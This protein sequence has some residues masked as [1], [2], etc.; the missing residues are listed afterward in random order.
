MSSRSR[1]CAQGARGHVRP[2]TERPSPVSAN[3]A[4]Q[5]VCSPMTLSTAVV[6][7]PLGVSGGGGA[8][9][10]S[11]QAPL[12]DTRWGRVGGGATGQQAAARRASRFYLEGA[13]VRTGSGTLF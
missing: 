4:S 12:L 5:S 13:A 1:D 2:L 7:H 8:P 3:L 10:F 9:G 6:A 11:L